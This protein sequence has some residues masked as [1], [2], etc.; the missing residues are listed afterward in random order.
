MRK[1]VI[2]HRLQAQERELG[3]TRRYCIAE[4]EPAIHIAS[5]FFHITN[6]EQTLA[7]CRTPAHMRRNIFRVG[8]NRQ[9]DS[10]SQIIGSVW[11]EVP[12]VLDNSGN[13]IAEA[14][15]CAE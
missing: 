5:P 1:F 2:R 6:P 10:P 14:H 4:K 9:R 7:G 8:S 3:F 13:V 12:P 15:A 11:H